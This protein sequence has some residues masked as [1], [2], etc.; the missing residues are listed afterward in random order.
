MAVFRG[1]DDM[2]REHG[3]AQRVAALHLEPAE[4]KECPPGTV[5]RQVCWRDED[6]QLVCEERCVPI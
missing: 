6:G 3:I 5:L 2:L 1:I 4:S